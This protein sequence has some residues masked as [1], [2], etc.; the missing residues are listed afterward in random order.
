MLHSLHCS[1][2]CQSSFPLSDKIL[3]WA[4]NYKEGSC[5]QHQVDNRLNKLCRVT[6]RLPKEDNKAAAPPALWSSPGV[7]MPQ[8]SCWAPMGA[9]CG[10]KQTWTCLTWALTATTGCFKAKCHL[11][12]CVDFDGGVKWHN[13]SKCGVWVPSVASHPKELSVGALTGLVLDAAVLCLSTG[14]DLYL[15]RYLSAHDALWFSP[16]WHRAGADKAACSAAVPPSQELYTQGTDSG[17]VTSITFLHYLAAAKMKP[18][19]KI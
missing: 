18:S 8:V 9:L 7:Q 3:I 15:H 10:T 14:L 6:R 17:L 19:C 2:L 16:P 5:T 1:A 12:A 11:L 13:A 4:G